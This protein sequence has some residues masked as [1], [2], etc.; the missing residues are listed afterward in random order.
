MP[1]KTLIIIWKQ[2]YSNFNP[3]QNFWGFGDLL[4]SLCGAS[5][6][7]KALG[8]N[9]VF[10]LRHH[11]I[12][13]CFVHQQHGYEDYIDGI[14]SKMPLKIFN[15]VEE[16]AGRLKLCLKNSNLECVSPWIGPGVFE[17]DISEHTKTT[18]KTLLTK[19]PEFE[20]YCKT[21]SPQPP[22]TVTHFRLGDTHMQLHGT[23]RQVA[24]TK[25]LN[26]YTDV[27]SDTLVISDSSTFKKLI[28]ESNLPNT[29]VSKVEPCHLGVEQDTEKIMSTLCEYF[30]L[31]KAR[32]ILTFNVYDRKSFSGFVLSINRLFDI[33]MVNLRSFAATGAPNGV[34]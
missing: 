24:H 15:S 13:K 5:E 17:R 23:N 29:V 26:T 3:E 28:T 12:S 30:M 34:I 9:V 11:P 4:R 18:L 33:P 19:T 21:H 27:I 2:H 31:T 25:L 22:Y 16:F 8:I 7:C 32:L 6:T 1:K 10:D 14:I 20:A